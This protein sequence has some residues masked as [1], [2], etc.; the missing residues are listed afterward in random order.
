[1]GEKLLVG[2]GFSLHIKQIRSVLL[3]T[4]THEPLLLNH[5]PYVPQITKNLLSVSKLLA[6]NDIT[7]NFL[8]ILVLSRPGAHESSYLEESQRD[9]CIKSKLHLNSLMIAQLC[10]VKLLSINLSLCLFIFLLCIV[11]I[12]MS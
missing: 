2:N 12:L 8:K 5:V 1:M 9:G 4:A 6:D 7:I 10:S 3:A 11:M